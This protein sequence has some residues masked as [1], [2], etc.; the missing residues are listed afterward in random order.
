MLRMGANVITGCH[1]EQCGMLKLLVSKR[2]ARLQPWIR[3]FIA[4]LLKVT[5]IEIDH[6]LP[7]EFHRPDKWGVDR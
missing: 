5:A 4:K 3:I 6:H 1:P 2:A 7:I